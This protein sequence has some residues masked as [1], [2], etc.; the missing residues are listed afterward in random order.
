M[1]QRRKRSS[2]VAAQGEAATKTTRVKKKRIQFIKSPTGRFF[3]AYNAG[4]I[5]DADT[6]CIKPKLKQ[7]IDEGYAQYV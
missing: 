3:L 1:T 4:Q 5:V 2:K 6:K 7:L